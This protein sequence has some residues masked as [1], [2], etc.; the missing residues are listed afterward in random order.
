[1]RVKYKL[2]VK[3]LIMITMLASMPTL[4]NTTRVNADTIENEFLSVSVITKDAALADCLST[5]LFN[6]S[7][8]EGKKL[9][10]KY[11][12]T[13]VMWIDKNYQIYY[14]DGLESFL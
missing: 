12:H 5:T 6:M 11:E 14:S 4:L 13:Y 1:M 2:K 9:I 8:D 3:N 10:M 7:I